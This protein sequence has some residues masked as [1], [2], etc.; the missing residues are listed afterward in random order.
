[1]TFLDI[2]LS[3]YVFL[4]FSIFPFLSLSL[5]HALSCL[6]MLQRAESQSV[7]HLITIMRVVVHRATLH[8]R[9]ERK[10]ARKKNKPKNPTFART[11]NKRRR[12]L[13]I[14]KGVLS[15]FYKNY[16]RRIFCCAPDTSFDS[17]L[18][19][20]GEIYRSAIRDEI[21]LG[22]KCVGPCG[23]PN[24]SRPPPSPRIMH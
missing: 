23:S 9:C 3:L 1:M 11:E 2:H 24:Y 10:E 22:E 15:I 18:A 8:V 12:E 14:L 21:R 4:S 19:R 5:F 17:G 20:C 6:H 13:H 16:G 7:L